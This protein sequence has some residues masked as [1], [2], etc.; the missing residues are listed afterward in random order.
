MKNITCLYPFLALFIL[1][2]CEGDYA[3]QQ[4]KVAMVSFKVREVNANEGGSLILLHIMFSKPAP[5]NG[6]ITIESSIDLAEILIHINS[7][8]RFDA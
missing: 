6:R 1:L 5:N 7:H 3:E 8:P 2:G 4:V